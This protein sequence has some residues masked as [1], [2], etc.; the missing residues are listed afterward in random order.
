M[1]AAKWLFALMALMVFVGCGQSDEQKM[2]NAADDMQKDAAKAAE[3]MEI[4]SLK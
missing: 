4:P 1:K 2:K 3:G